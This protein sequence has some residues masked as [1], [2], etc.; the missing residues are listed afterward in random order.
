MVST[1][2]HSNRE[3]DL[4]TFF[5]IHSIEK[6]PIF[7]QRSESSKIPKQVKW[8]E[9]WKTEE[10][11]DCRGTGIDGIWPCW[12]EGDRQKTGVYGEE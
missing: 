3:V 8:K 1:C 2:L 12:N 5:E 11:L 6:M 7:R 9:K 4:T 10:I